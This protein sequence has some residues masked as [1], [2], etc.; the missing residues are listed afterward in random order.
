MKTM[1]KMTMR[2]MSDDPTSYDVSIGAGN[3]RT[4]LR[5]KSGDLQCRTLDRRRA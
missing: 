2:T 1:K 4:R 5:H 3:A